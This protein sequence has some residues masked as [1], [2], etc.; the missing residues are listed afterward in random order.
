MDPIVNVFQADSFTAATLTKAVQE[1]PGVYPE[2]RVNEVFTDM[3]IATTSVQIDKED[4]EF[5]LIPQG[6][7]GGGKGVKARQSTRSA[8]NWAVP[9]RVLEDTVTGKDIQDK[10]A[11]GS[12]DLE[13]AENV[14]LNKLFKM[15]N[16][17]DMTRL[18]YKMQ[19]LQGKIVDPDNATIY[20]AFTELA[21]TRKT[22]DFALATSTT[23]I[24]SK[25]LELSDEV[26]E[27]LTGTPFS[28]IRVYA[29]KLWFRNFVEHPNVKEAYKYYESVVS[30]M[31]ND[32]RQGFVHGGVEFVN[33]PNKLYVVDQLGAKSVKTLVPS[34]EAFAVPVGTDLAEEYFSPADHIE[35]ANQLGQPMYA[36]SVLDQ[37]Y[38]K[39][40][41]MS[42]SATLPVFKKPAALVKLT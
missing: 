16:S 7:R 26:G 27:R 12:N 1:A 14:T 31:R 28:G 39:L 6:V 11:L 30:P 10:R 41:L 13:T 2:L 5:N 18:Y 4:M 32:V 21:I 22:I 8:Q 38:G 33:V 35:F 23:N 42:Q 15:G 24:L 34:N 17:H 9:I 19:A 36:W 40:D 20:D 25:I 29:D 3:P 37:K